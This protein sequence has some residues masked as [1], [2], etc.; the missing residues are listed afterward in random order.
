[1]TFKQFLGK[2]FIDVLQWN[3][4]EVGML[5]YRYESPQVVFAAEI[6]LNGAAGAEEAGGPSG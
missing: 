3:E 4:P 1:M 2:Q 6:P 5:A